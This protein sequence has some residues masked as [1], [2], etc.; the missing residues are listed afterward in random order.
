MLQLYRKF[1]KVPN[2][3]STISIIT[4]SSS[5]NPTI[6]QEGKLSMGFPETHT[7][8]LL[9][10]CPPMELVVWVKA[11]AAKMAATREVEPKLS[12]RAKLLSERGQASEG[13]SPVT[14]RDV[15]HMKRAEAGGRGLLKA[16]GYTPKAES[17]LLRKRKRGLEGK[18]NSG[19]SP[20]LSGST[21]GTSRRLMG[22]GEGEDL[23]TPKRSCGDLLARSTPTR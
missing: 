12:T 5:F 20:I 14:A 6:L 10:N 19:E 1:V 17:P 18:E 15:S 16:R 3:I 7:K 4:T 11:L 9:S 13:I 22:E 23:P 8:L 21:Q 2:I